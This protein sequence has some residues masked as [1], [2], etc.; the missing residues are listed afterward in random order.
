MPRKTIAEHLCPYYYRKCKLK[1]CSQRPSTEEVLEG[2]DVWMKAINKLR[3][4]PHA[5]SELS[6]KDYQSRQEYIEEKKTKEK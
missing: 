3:S 6:K 4:C 5:G 2:F 1:T